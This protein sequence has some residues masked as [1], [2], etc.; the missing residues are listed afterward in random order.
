[1]KNFYIGAAYYPEL[2]D[3]SEVE[4]DIAK[5]KEYGMNCMRIGE[6]AWSSIEPEEG[7]V[8]L[9]F[10]KYVVDKLYENGIY[11]VMCT[12]SCTP[13]R[14]VFNKYPDAMRI[15]SE[16]FVL[17]KMDVHAR[18]HPCKSH[19]G[20]RQENVRIARELARE[21]A[22]H[23]GVIGWQIDNEIYPFDYGCFCERCRQGFREYLKEKF[24]TIENL[25]KSWG[26]YRWSL[27]YSTFDEIQPPSWKAW[28]NP[29]RNVEWVRYQTGLIKSYVLEQAEAIREYSSAPIGTDLT[30]GHL[31]SYNKMNKPLDVVQ[32]NHYNTVE[33]LY[34]STFK[35]DL[36]RTLKQR[37]FWI[38]ETL[39][40]WNGSLAA[41]DGY[42]S[43]DYCYINSLLPIAHGAEMN[44]YWHFRSHP[45]GHEMGHG[46]FLNTAGR[47]NSSSECVKMITE[48]LSK[49]EELLAKTKV[50]S[51]IALTY[52]A[53]SAKMFNF[54]PI[55]EGFDNDVELKFVDHFH[56]S[57]RHYNVDVIELDKELDGY[58]VILSPFLA[59]LELDG[60]KERIVKWIENGGTWIVG[61]LSDIM[62][63]N[64]S[65]YKDA[66]YSFLEELC[67][68]YTKYQLPVEDSRFTAHFA[69]GEEIKTA[70]GCDAYVLRGAE[71]LATYDSE[72]LDCLTAIA[73]RK[74][75]KGQVIILGTAVDKASL[76]RLIDREPILLASDNID[77]V[78]RFGEENVI[79]AM[80]IEGKD[81][82]ITLDNEYL[83]VLNDRHISGKIELKPYSALILKRK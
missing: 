63:E 37:P 65:K 62:D 43:A 54:V 71:S 46:A 75:G 52:S 68:V 73:R 32:H 64:T 1:M 61:P 40:G 10:F 83:D 77:L 3:K 49:S 20:I 8:N 27:N 81:G 82:Y 67:G 23:P 78:E 53:D 38:T 31:V 80:E 41:C 74:Y 42:R 7:K 48:T 13:P 70:M 66:P 12:P 11:T 51:K 17:T 5:M 29:S 36:C 25:N 59:C 33:D 9:D 76:L 18:V 30:S 47:P 60:F 56:K 72:E 6:F 50:K 21:F 19:K 15:R 44:L 45:N 39:L 35:F 2:W 34:R 28:E 16:R 24:G 79:I 14:W 26:M 55:V 22:N 58:E 57:L 4:R 69:S